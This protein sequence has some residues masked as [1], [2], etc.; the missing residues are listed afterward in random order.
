MHFYNV[1]CQNNKFMNLYSQLILTT[2]KIIKIIV[3]T[4]LQCPVW[5]FPALLEPDHPHLY[6]PSSH[7]QEDRACRWQLALAFSWTRQHYPSLMDLTPGLYFTFRIIS[8]PS[9]IS[10][11]IL[12]SLRLLSLIRHTQHTAHSTRMWASLPFPLLPFLLLP[13]RANCPEVAIE[14]QLQWSTTRERYH[15]H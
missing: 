6:L 13:W 7:E 8:F 3:K 11:S 1:N 10:E 2:E 9:L 14:F 5:P 12:A 4:N 15:A